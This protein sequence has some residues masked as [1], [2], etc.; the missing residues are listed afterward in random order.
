MLAS[1]RWLRVQRS[2]QTGQKLS[3]PILPDSA[4]G[5]ALT[6]P[7]STAARAKA[8]IAK[9]AIPSVFFDQHLQLFGDMVIL[10]IVLEKHVRGNLLLPCRPNERLPHH[11]SSF[12]GSSRSNRDAVREHA[13]CQFGRVIVSPFKKELYGMKPRLEHT[14][15][16]RRKRLLVGLPTKCRRFPAGRGL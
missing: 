4:A 7:T 14:T 12:L 16:S 1:P 9:M 15:N 5:A 6:V 2:F 10:L 8:T 3:R 13:A 11:V